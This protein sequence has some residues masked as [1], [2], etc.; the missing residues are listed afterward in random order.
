M[1]AGEGTSYLNDLQSLQKGV[2]QTLHELAINKVS[3]RHTD[4]RV[5]ERA[6]ATHYQG[7]PTPSWFKSCVLHLGSSCCVAP[8]VVCTENFERAY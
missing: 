3:Y 6:D 8:A 2:M 7:D 4:E 5:D 1:R